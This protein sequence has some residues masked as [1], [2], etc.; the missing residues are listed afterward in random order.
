[1]RQI[2]NEMVTSNPII[3][4]LRQDIAILTQRVGSVTDAYNSEIARLSTT[5]CRCFSRLHQI[6]IA[7]IPHLSMS[8]S[9]YVETSQLT[10]ELLRN[11]N[12]LCHVN[13]V[14]QSNN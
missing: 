7:I 10:Y 2:Q 6:L 4:Q 1:M 3:N 8:P 14:P 13:E 5:T 12:Q 11:I 9:N